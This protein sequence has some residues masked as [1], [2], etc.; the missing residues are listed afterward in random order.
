MDRSN[1][2]LRGL[3]FRSFGRSG[4]VYALG[5]AEGLHS[6]RYLPHCSGHPGA[7][8][9]VEG[10]RALGG[11]SLHSSAKTLAHGNV[12]ATSESG[13]QSCDAA[14]APAQK[15]ELVLCCFLLG[16]AVEERLHPFF[17]LLGIQVFLVCAHAPGMTKG[18]DKAPVAITPELVRHRHALFASSRDG[19]LEQLLKDGYVAIHGECIT[20]PS[21]WR[22][23]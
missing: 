15:R 9:G 6:L 5:A 17:H 3:I 10:A 14:R 11:G 22:L 7:G 23:C 21:L 12:A 18:I 4:L 1:H 2:R 19:L 20:T 16:H 8:L 13:P